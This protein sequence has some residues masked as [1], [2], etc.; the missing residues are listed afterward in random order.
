MKFFHLALIVGALPANLINGTTA[1]ATQV[2]A[3]LNWIVNQVNAN[4]A[5]LA[6][7]ALTNANNNF[8]TVQSGQPATQ[9]ANFPIAS[10]I[11]NN[12]LQT[13][14]SVLGTNTI[15]AR[16]S[17]LP[18][19]AYVSGQIFTFYPSNAN[20]GA[21][22]VNIDGVGAR[23]L[24]NMGSGLSGAEL[25]SYRPSTLVFN[26]AVN[27]FDLLNGTPYVQGPNL[28]AAATLNLDGTFGDYSQVDGTASIT[29]MTLSRGRQKLLEF[30]SSPLI[31]NSSNLIMGSNFVPNPGDTAVFRGEASGVVRMVGVKRFAA[32]RQTKRTVLL[33]GAGNYTPDPGATRLDVQCV[34][35]G[36]GGGASTT[37]AGSNGAGT[38]FGTLSAGGGN[39]GN[40]GSGTGQGGAGGV[41]TGGDINIAGGT[42]TAGG[43]TSAT[44]LGGD[45]A[46]GPF[47]GGSGGGRTTIA[48]AGA[49]NSGSGG[50]GGGSAANNAGGGGAGAYCRK[51]F[52]YPLL[53][54][55]AYSVGAGGA[56]G[57]AGTTAGANGG[58]GIIIVDE[59]YD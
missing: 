58:S 52:T 23:A 19:G 20:T 6:T 3:D 51:L 30:N 53:A 5:P 9:P 34:G 15:T 41:A 54:S 1:D 56:G 14:S 43:S 49:A 31:V 22:T 13:L 57:A 4:A 27:A 11:E 29:A 24:L 37:N 12:S 36:G 17:A 44:G 33:T 10:Q 50:A 46:S 47:G 8:T 2:M 25:Q 7:T 18:L 16:V 40:I 39:G 38:T 28:S 42:G 35:D 26:G 55:Y 59:F 45:G 21:T 32:A 48:S